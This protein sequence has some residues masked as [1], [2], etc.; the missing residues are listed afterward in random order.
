MSSMRLLLAALVLLVGLLGTSL[1]PTISATSTSPCLTIP[2]TGTGIAFGRGAA[3]FAGTLVIRQ[4]AVSP[5]DS[6]ELMAIGAISGTL[7]LDDGTLLGTVTDVVLIGPLHVTSLEADLS[8]LTLVVGLSGAVFKALGTSMGVRPSTFHLS[9]GTAGKQGSGQ[10]TGLI[11]ALPAL[12]A[13]Q[14]L[15][16]I[17]WRLN[18]TCTD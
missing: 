4:F 13:A 18:A 9:V 16:V 8:A 10:L 17:A 12:L 5:Y 11:H 14:Q 1:A 6:S 15:D 2:V 3:A 7:S